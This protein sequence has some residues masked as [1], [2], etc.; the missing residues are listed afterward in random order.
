MAFPAQA[1]YVAQIPVATGTLTLAIAVEGEDA[2][3]YACDGSYQVQQVVELHGPVDPAAV[4]RAVDWIVARH[5]PLRASFHVLNDEGD[6]DA[7]LDA[8]AV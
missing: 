4:R 6:V 8:L 7:A 5:A 2:V 3:A 1:T